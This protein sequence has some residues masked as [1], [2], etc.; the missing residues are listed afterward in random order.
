MERGGYALAPDVA[1]TAKT[2]PTFLV[3]AAGQPTQSRVCL[4]TRWR[5]RAKKVPMELHVYPSGGHGYELRPKQYG[6]RCGSRLAQ[7]TYT[8]PLSTLLTSC[9]CG[10]SRPIFRASRL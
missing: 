2:P 6:G 10:V 5:S 7:S 4:A 8:K 9:D 3:M 1:V